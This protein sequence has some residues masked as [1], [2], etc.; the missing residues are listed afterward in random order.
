[1][2]MAVAGLM[3][4]HQ[5]G[6]GKTLSQINLNIR[7]KR[8]GLR[9]RLM[10]ALQRMRMSCDSSYLLDEESTDGR[11]H[12]TDGIDDAAAAVEATLDGL[13]EVNLG[14][15][16]VGTGL[17][18]PDGYRE[19]ALAHLA[20]ISGLEVRGATRPVSATTDP[21][22]LLALSSG[23]RACAVALARVANDLRLLSSGPRA[24][25]AEYHLPPRQAGSSMM[26]GKVNP[27]I[28]EYVNQLAF[29]VRGLDAAA[30]MALDA[31]QLQLNAMLPVVAE[32]LIESQ[33]LIGEAA[34]SLAD[35]CIDGLEIDERRMAAAAGDGL[36]EVT[37]LAAVAGYGAATAIT[38]TA[39]KQGVPPDTLARE[40]SVEAV[41][42][43]HAC[44]G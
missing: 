22:A 23:L 11:C 40:R 13:L 33:A 37:E 38:A 17:A 18:T 1:M 19:R 28:P 42:S 5:V 34:K 41:A 26:P 6:F 2:A 8:L 30:T 43:P 12:A 20:E 44:D 29:R 9:Q 24:G 35:R 31:G 32:S 27:V 10:I 25:L 15:T 4:A 14:G 3:M 16:A 7:L 39:R 21:V 36:G